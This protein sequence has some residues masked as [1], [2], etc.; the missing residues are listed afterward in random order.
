M[1]ENLREITV[2]VAKQTAEAFEKCSENEKL[3]IGEIIDRC[4]LHLKSTDPEIAVETIMQTAL[5]VI[6]VQNKEQREETFLKIAGQ[7]IFYLSEGNPKNLGQVL[8]DMEVSFVETM[9]TVRA[10]IAKI[11]EKQ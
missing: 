10:Q 9:D 7:L 3:T 1:E 4:V 6:S 8:S 5:T 2:T 11:K